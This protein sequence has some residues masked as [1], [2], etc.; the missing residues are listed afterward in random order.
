MYNDNNIEHEFLK[1]PKTNPFR[2]PDAYFDSIED[3]I[4][5]Q[6]KQTRQVKTTSARIIQ[7]LKPA[8][9]LVASFTLVYM[10]AYYPI[11][12]LKV[13]N[14]SKAETAANS[15]IDLPDNSSFSLSL[16]DDN[17]LANAIFSDEPNSLSEANP[18]EVLAYLSSDLND[19]DI[20]SE[21]QN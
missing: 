4:M 20:Y 16:I 9:G 6:V 14:G 7:F 10:L 21:I 2:V 8:L 15:S 12:N 11:H 5:D 19:V 13:K 3:R 17:T 18:D 1:R